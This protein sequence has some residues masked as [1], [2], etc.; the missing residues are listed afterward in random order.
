ML[1]KRQIRTVAQLSIYWIKVFF[2]I[3][4]Y[5]ILELLIKKHNFINYAE[6]GVYKGESINH[7]LKKTELQTLFLIEKY[8][9][10]E[11]F[12]KYKD[13]QRV[14]CFFID[15]VLASKKFPNKSLDIVFIDGDHSYK[16]VIKD[17][18]AW[19]PKIRKGGI[20]AGHDFI[21]SN[22]GVI[23]AVHERFNDPVIES[24][25]VWY[26]EIE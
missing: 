1:L 18:D 7:L 20:I 4:R 3:R 15:S 12:K 11:K 25:F 23:K 16:Q 21:N 17:I 14:K 24:D 19:L 13:N 22:F 6:I 9:I 2:R 8:P 26:K 10:K 5:E